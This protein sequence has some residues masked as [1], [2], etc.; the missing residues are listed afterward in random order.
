MN[1]PQIS[2][3]IDYFRFLVLNAQHPVF[4]ANFSFLKNNFEVLD[5]DLGEANYS[6]SVPAVSSTTYRQNALR[7]RRRQSAINRE[8]IVASPPTLQEIEA[9]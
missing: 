6:E 9:K 7:S 3:I 5:Q 8:S 1:L 2:R 4:I